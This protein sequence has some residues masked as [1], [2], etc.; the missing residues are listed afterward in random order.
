MK[1]PNLEKLSETYNR[2]IMTNSTFRENFQ[3]RE[4]AE[5]A[6][7]KPKQ[8]RMKKGDVAMFIAEN[9]IKNELQLLNIA[10][11]RR[12][13]G[14]RCLYDY[15]ME[16]QKRAREELMVDAWCFEN[17]SQMI[18]DNNVDCI[19]KIQQNSTGQCICERMWLSSAKEVLAQNNI[20][21]ENFA[22]AIKN[23]LILGRRKET[24]ILLYGPA[25]CGKTFLLKSVCKILPNV[26][27]NPA[28]STFGWIGVEN[29]NLIFLNDLIWKPPGSKHG[30]ID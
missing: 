11:E 26:F 1:H 7:K 29:S 22:S 5:P 6:P 13:L 30:N 16:L 17:A 28:V 18:K 25:D 19:G 14:D 8:N 23:A 12:N 4:L 27:L 15:L 24:N 10:T 9:D 21:Y 20:E 3:Q 2:A